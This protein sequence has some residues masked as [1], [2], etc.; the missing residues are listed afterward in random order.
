MR[1]TNLPNI[2]ISF[3]FKGERWIARVGDIGIPIEIILDDGRP[4]QIAAQ[5]TSQLLQHG[6]SIHMI[7]AA[8]FG[9]PLAVLLDKVIATKPR[10]TKSAD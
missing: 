8:V 6:L 9:G 2:E 3:P 4:H 10:A 7:R 5:L 1:I